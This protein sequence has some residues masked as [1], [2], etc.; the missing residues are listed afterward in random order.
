LQASLSDLRAGLAK[1][2]ANDLG[3]LF[4]D[5]MARMSQTIDA[6]F[7]A[8]T[9]QSESLSSLVDSLAT[10]LSAIKIRV[11]VLES[12]DRTTAIQEGLE[13]GRALRAGPD[14]SGDVKPSQAS[15]LQAESESSMPRSVPPSA[16]AAEL[17]KVDP[18][19]VAT[20]T[21]TP[22]QTVQFDPLRAPKLPK[23]EPEKP[24]QFVA[25]VRASARFNGSKP[26]LAALLGVL[27]SSEHSEVSEFFLA[28]DALDPEKDC[29]SW[30]LSILKAF[31]SEKWE[32]RDRLIRAP[33]FVP[34]S[35]PP[36][37][38]MAEMIALCKEAGCVEE[39]MLV[40]L[41]SKVPPSAL[42]EHKSASMYDSVADLCAGMTKKV[43]VEAA[44]SSAPSTVGKDASGATSVGPGKAASKVN[45]ATKTA[46]SSASPKAGV[47][48]Y[49][50]YLADRSLL[51]TSK[52]PEKPCRRCG[53]FHWFSQTK[54]TE[55][56]KSATTVAGVNFGEVVDDDFYQFEDVL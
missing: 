38:W 22:S 41:A 35:V 12:R 25:V 10:S 1:E 13:K 18:Q 50:R 11:E 16:A 55:P 33:P 24:R 46:A 49:R 51:D 6:R 23:F 47:D 32:A 43:S 44:R 54:C 26:T 28:E 37:R 14:A 45:P 4:Q 17:A 27:S 56:G 52:P 9:K 40:M 36:R 2:L 20:S 3:S 29:E 7:E 5:A 21:S 39:Q 15:L 34:G 30:C 42:P 48:G 19:T 53:A 8:I 31:G